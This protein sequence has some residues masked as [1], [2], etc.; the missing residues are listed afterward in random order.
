MR[1]NKVPVLVSV[2]MLTYNHESFIKKA[3]EGVLK[4]KTSFHFNLVIGED[5][6]TDKTKEIVLQYAEKYPDKIKVVTSKS[7]VGITK[8]SQRTHEACEGKY[9]AYCEGD[10]WWIDDHKLEK[11]VKLLEEN[12]EYGMVHTDAHFRNTQTGELK[13]NYLKSNFN[14]NHYQSFISFQDQY[15]KLLTKKTEVITAT[16]IARK[17]LV[18][19]ARKENPLSFSNRFVAKDAPTWLEISR[20]SKIHFLPEATA[21]RNELPESASRSNNK[22]RF[23]DYIFSL[24][25]S[26]IHYINKYPISEKAYKVIFNG[27][28]SKWATNILRFSYRHNNFERAQKLKAIYPEN[29]TIKQQVFYWASKYPFIHKNWLFNYFRKT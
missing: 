24:V 22:E 23:Y 1:Q 19:K 21:I 8:N 25:D 28:L 6:S 12:P 4:Q 26:K 5:C 3:I 15:E 27:Y 2:K 14:T 7:N 20:L 9:M 16:V 29:F 11:Q 17:D 10:D 13:T 18:D